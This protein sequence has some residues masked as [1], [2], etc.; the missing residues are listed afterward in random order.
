M[1]SSFASVED[2]G[3]GSS[4]GFPQQSLQSVEQT[5]NAS[6]GFPV[7]NE[8]DYFVVVL[9]LILAVFLMMIL[10]VVFL[11]TVVAYLIFACL[12]SLLR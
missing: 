3:L 11:V 4:S 8:E 10:L 9:G 7:T 2:Q 6:G 1:P 12:V 5:E